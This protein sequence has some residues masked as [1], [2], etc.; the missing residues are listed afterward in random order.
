M[1]KMFPLRDEARF[2]E[3][4]RQTHKKLTALE[5]L[6]LLELYQ[7]PKYSKRLVTMIREKNLLEA[8]NESEAVIGDLTLFLEWGLTS[9]DEKGTFPSS[10]IF[11]QWLERYIHR[12][13]Y[14]LE[15]LGW[16]FLD[17]THRLLDQIRSAREKPDSPS[18][19]L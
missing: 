1:T 5:F 15:R 8:S 18:H 7:S 6:R 12:F 16:E 4:S 9:N 19:P 17:E 13:Q 3:Y 11:E 2:R 14:R 10:E